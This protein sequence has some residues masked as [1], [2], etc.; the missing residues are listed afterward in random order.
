MILAVDIGN[1]TIAIAVVQNCKVIKRKTVDSTLKPLR[2]NAQLNKAI[3]VFKKDIRLCERI[4]ICSVV[5]QMTKTVCAV[6]S[7]CAFPKPVVIGKDIK[8]PIKNKYRRPSQV[9]QDRLVCAFA[10][11]RLY[12]TP[13]IVVDLGTAITFDVISKKGEYL[14]GLIIPGLKMSLESLF[15][16]TALLPRVEIRKPK[17]LIGKDTKSSILSGIFHGYGVLSDGLIHQISKEIKGKPVVV[18]TGGFTDLI[19]I[20][21]RN[22]SLID[23]DLSLK[24]MSL[25]DVNDRK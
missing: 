23:K 11:K 6:L 24:G 18:A 19:K 3:A 13:C 14:G 7:K 4:Y 12:G 20:F 15:N 17:E 5:P 22:I 25:V 21:S 16:K 8:V 10:A 1:S 9:G 2:L